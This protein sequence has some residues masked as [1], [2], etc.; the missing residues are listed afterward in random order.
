MPRT[1]TDN[2]LLVAKGGNLESIQVVKIQISRIDEEFLE[3]KENGIFGKYE[4]YKKFVLERESE[5]FEKRS[6]NILIFTEKEWFEINK[7][8]GFIK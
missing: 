1:H 2:F 4:D 6:A 8:L 5:A 3:G 7:S